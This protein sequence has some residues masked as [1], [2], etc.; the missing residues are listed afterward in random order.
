MINIAKLFSIPN[1]QRSFKMLQFMMDM[2]VSYVIP[3][4][5][6]QIFEVGVVKP[7]IQASKRFGTWFF[8]VLRDSET[9]TWFEIIV[10]WTIE[11]SLGNW[12]SYQE[13]QKKRCSLLLEFSL[14]QVY[15]LPLRGMPIR[16]RELVQFLNLLIPS[17][18]LFCPFFFFHIQ[19]FIEIAHNKE[20]VR[21]SLSSRTNL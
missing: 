5:N 20:R 19:N 8:T 13:S 3:F 1:F 18:S 4:R 9:P 2:K 15:F 16:F 6:Y 11:M 10:W 17:V 21:R 12:L 14:Y 7:N